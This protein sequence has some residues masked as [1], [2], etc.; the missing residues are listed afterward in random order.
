MS[1]KQ[2]SEQR[3]GPR[4]HCS[5]IRWQQQA[6]AWPCYA[7]CPPCL[8]VT[9]CPLPSLLAEL[10]DLEPLPVTALANPVYE[11]L[12]KFSHFN[13]IQ[14]QVTAGSHPSAWLC[15]LQRSRKTRSAG[16]TVAVSVVFVNAALC[17]ASPAPSPFCP[18]HAPCNIQFHSALPRPATPNLN[19]PSPLQAFHTLYHSDHPVLLG[20]PTGSG[21]TISAELCMLRLFSRYPG[22]K[23]GA[24]W[25]DRAGV[26][27]FP[28]CLQVS[29]VD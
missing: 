4:R 21:K 19:W 9:G 25:C 3:S 27:H 1:C 16:L 11:S 20:A 5:H 26:W 12:Y 17:H 7:C 24:A 6:G 2:P 15:I 10:M 13:P 23:V 29:R 28:C 18:T 14:T 22:Q 8:H